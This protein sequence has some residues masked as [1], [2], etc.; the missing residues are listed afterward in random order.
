MVEE[1]SWGSKAVYDMPWCVH[2]TTMVNQTLDYGHAYLFFTRSDTES[3]DPKVVQLAVSGHVIEQYF[4]IA[5]LTV[6]VYHARTHHDYLN[7]KT[8]DGCAYPNSS[9]YDRQG[10]TFTVLNP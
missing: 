1:T 8:A 10:G 6:L 9:F 4:S 7:L 5:L 2:S 3:I